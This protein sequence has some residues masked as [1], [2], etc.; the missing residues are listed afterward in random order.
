MD[1]P[2]YLLIGG[3]GGIG[4]ALAAHLSGA[5]ATVVLASRDRERLH[6]S[7]FPFYVADAADP[8]QVDAAVEFCCREYGKLDGAVNCAGSILLKAAHQTSAA[9]WHSVITTNLTTAFFTV[10]ACSKAMMKNGGSIVLLSSAAARSGIAN[11]DAIAAAK[12]GVVGLTLSA[13]A[14]YA[15]YGIR[16]NCVAPGLVRTPLSAR[17]T[18]SETALKASE[19]MHALGRIGEPAEVAAAI[20]WL[21]Q[22]PWI[23]GQILGVDGGLATVRSR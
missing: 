14:T 11:H 4:S 17:I 2:V 7:G 10:R 5:G 6:A 18:S 1:S 8:A 3:A 13:A 16:V 20:A 21:L 9:E 15:R 19:A 22:Q 23:T 12:A